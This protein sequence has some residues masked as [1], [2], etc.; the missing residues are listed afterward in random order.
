MK[1]KFKT[2][3]GICCALVFVL[4]I[5]GLVFHTG[6]GTASSFGISSIAAICPLG[7]L[8]TLFTGHNFNLHVFIA[9]A[10]VL[11]LA[12]FTGKAFCAWVCP[13]PYISHFFDKDGKREKRQRKAEEKA[14]EAASKATDEIADEIADETTNEAANN[15]TDEQALASTG[16]ES[17]NKQAL[18]PIGGKSPNKQ[19]LAPTGGTRDGAH[20]DSRVIVLG[21]ALLSSA[22]FGFPVFC[23][24]C[25]IGLTF[26]TVIAIFHVLHFAEV[27][28]S[29]LLYPAIIVIELVVLR[30]WCASFCPVG[31]LL[32]LL[33]NL[34]KTFKPQVKND[35]CLRN[36]GTDCKTCV[37]TCPERLDP[38]SGTIPE[39][40][41]C[42]ECVD[43]CPAHAIEMR[44]LAGFTERSKTKRGKETV[45]TTSN[46]EPTE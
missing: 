32:S 13:T 16:G 34:N 40:T 25:P 30:K 42:G 7:A 36:G 10:V 28:W 12:T 8:E 41:K 5:I 35:L 2:L 24:V 21:G 11:V 3:R 26:A 27:T 29:L 20:V 33:S 18:T 45:N 4:V 23:L 19:A 37:N 38:H 31:A 9:L 44:L 1:A 6:T 46:N 22:V 14:A 15:I 43:A 17:P 39:C